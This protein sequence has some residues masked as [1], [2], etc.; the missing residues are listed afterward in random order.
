MT[1]TPAL[2]SRAFALCRQN[3]GQVATAQD[4]G[5]SA[6]ARCAL[7]HSE[8]VPEAPLAAGV[9]AVVGGGAAAPRPLHLLVALNQGLEMLHQALTHRLTW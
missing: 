6:G 2:I 3:F 5:G 9:A 8:R 4:L 7:A 1:W